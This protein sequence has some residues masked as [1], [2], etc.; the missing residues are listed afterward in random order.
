[1]LLLFHPD[2]NVGA[3]LS[4]HAWCDA[5]FSYGEEIAFDHGE[6]T[7]NQAICQLRLDMYLKII[8]NQY[9]GRITPYWSQSRSPGSAKTTIMLLTVSLSCLP[10]TAMIHTKPVTGVEERW[11]VKSKKEPEGKKKLLWCRRVHLNPRVSVTGLV[12]IIK[13]LMVNMA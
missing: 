9:N 1:M 2:T 3:N 7:N 13:V 12:R 4:E 6:T 8:N 5:V 11:S 10:F